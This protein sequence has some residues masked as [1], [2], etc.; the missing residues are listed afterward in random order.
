MLHSGIY[1][2]GGIIHFLHP[3]RTFHYAFTT[4]L[5]AIPTLGSSHPPGHKVT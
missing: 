3:E 1:Q 2:K 5:L 4:Q